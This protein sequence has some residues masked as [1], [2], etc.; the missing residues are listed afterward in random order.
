MMAKKKPPCISARRKFKFKNFFSE[1]YNPSSF[2]E[3]FIYFR[4]L[5]GASSAIAIAQHQQ[6]R[7]GATTQ[8]ITGLAAGYYKV[9]V[10]DAAF[11]TA[12]ADVTLTEPTVL[13]VGLTPSTYPPQTT[14]ISC[15]NCCN[16][17]INSAPTGGTAGYTYAWTSPNASISSPSS[18]N[19]SGLCAGTFILTVT[20]AHGCTVS[21]NQVLTQPDKDTWAQSGNSGSNPPTQF[22]GTTDNKD[23]VI[24]SNGSERARL[25]ANG[26]FQITRIVTNRIV[27]PDTVIIFGDSSVIIKPNYNQIYG[28]PNGPSFQG[29]GLGNTALAAGQYAI[30]A[31][32]RTVAS[33]QYSMAIGARVTASA[34][35][36]YVFGTG[37]ISS[38]IPM[39]NSISNSIMMGCNS[40]SVTLFISGANGAGTTGAVGIGTR[41]I[42]SSCK[43]AV[44]GDIIAQK[45]TVQL[46]ANWP[47]YV[48]KN[49]YKLLSLGSLEE[50]I[51]ENHH[52]PGMPSADEIEK[53]G[54]DLGDIQAKLL[55]QNEE[56]TLRVIELNKRIEKLENEKK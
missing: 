25:K 14:N 8:N 26:D 18:A 6:G 12:A 33:A 24:K 4:F 52:L 46:Y 21:E 28:D 36:S 17:Y 9:T 27:S 32:F 53:N 50:F 45:V 7:N 38:N 15:Y 5:V 16:G 34:Q 54:Q 31:G 41:K 20:D 44:K 19:I 42:P 48:F 29:T 10:T 30:A 13:G 37:I 1:R 35:S 2:I 55:K 51:N 49:D 47:D 22:I 11:A 43:L 40:D 56:L 3:F 39:V 23:F